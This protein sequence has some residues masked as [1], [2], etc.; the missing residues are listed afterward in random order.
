[1]ETGEERRKIEETFFCG[2]ERG[3][4]D[5]RTEQKEDIYLLG[6]KER[7]RGKER[8]REKD[9]S[10]TGLWRTQLFLK[11]CF[12]VLV[13]VYL[14]IITTPTHTKA[15]HGFHVQRGWSSRK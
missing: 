7:E 14:T 10:G 9:F 4:C 2:R 8:E 6:V 12:I 11:N 5:H 15:N 13:V 1:L 3:D